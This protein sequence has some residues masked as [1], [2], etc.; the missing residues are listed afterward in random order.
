MSQQNNLYPSLETLMISEVITGKKTVYQVKQT[1]L[2]NLQIKY[3]KSNQS[4]VKSTNDTENINEL[5]TSIN[6][7]K[8]NNTV[9]IPNTYHKQLISGN[10][11][12]H[13]MIHTDGIKEIIIVKSQCTSI[14]IGIVCIDNCQ[15]VSYIENKSVASN[16]PLRVGDQII[17]INSLETAG[18]NEKQLLSYIS[19]LGVTINLL[20]RDRPLHKVFELYKDDANKLGIGFKNGIITHLEINSSAAKN[21]IPTGHKIVEINSQN[22]IGLSDP[23]IVKILADSNI[24]VYIG[25]IKYRDYKEL[26]KGLNKNKL[27]SM[28][29]SIQL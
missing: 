3:K 11:M 26:I 10:P 25:L 1:F 7:H 6:K 28:D 13:N 17:R 16:T 23:E 22:V 4:F 12:C 9:S 14:G 21:G 20:V 15:F 29:H 19:K 5:L 2:Q 18:L 27:N 24:Q 8:Y